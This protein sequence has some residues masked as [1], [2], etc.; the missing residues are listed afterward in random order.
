[1]MIKNGILGHLAFTGKERDSET[2][3]GYFGARYMDHEL[4]TMWLSVDP[5]ADKYPGISPYAYCVWNPMR[6]VDPN[7][8]DIWEIDRKGNVV[9]KE[10]SENTIVYAVD[11]QGRR[12]GATV[13]LSNDDILNQLKG[14]AKKCQRLD[15]QGT[16]IKTGKLQ[17]AIST[18][19]KDIVKLFVFASKYT[20]VE[21]GIYSFKKANSSQYGITTFQYDDETPSPFRFA[22]IKVFEDVTKWRVSTMIHSHPNPKTKEEEVLSLFGDKSTAQSTSYNYYT[23]MSHSGNLYWINKKGFHSNK[24]TYTSYESLMKIF[25]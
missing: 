21:W 25:K 17:A 10:K 13:D 9:W 1:M 14:H 3:Y 7:V 22:Q 23:Y 12:T 15:A 6:L 8:R 19:K 20:D 16:P 4:M 2:G 24:G 5:M 11:S 18:N